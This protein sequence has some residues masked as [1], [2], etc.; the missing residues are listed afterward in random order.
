MTAHLMARRAYARP[1]VFARNPRAVEYDLLAQATAALSSAW[2]QRETDFPHL[3]KALDANLRLWTLLGADV[4]NPEN[5]LPQTLRTRLFYLSQFTA[6]HSRAVL[7]GRA[8]IGVLV[9]INTA[10][11]RGLRGEGCSA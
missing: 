1:D 10:V 2:V 8:S 6:E 9:D 7:E 5:G 11:M 3:A 4:A